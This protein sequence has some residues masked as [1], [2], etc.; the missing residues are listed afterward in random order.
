MMEQQTLP[1]GER[2]LFEILTSKSVL[3]RAY[4]EVRRNKGAP[5]VEGV[6]V[7]DFA[8]RREEELT[9]LREELLSW[10]YKPKPVKRV[11]I[12]KLLGGV[13][14]LGIPC[15]RDRVCKRG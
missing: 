14:Q 10:A 5:G 9:H 13:R 12:P 3:R 6:T 1:L 4:E 7:E 2:K 11:E 8:C 15:V